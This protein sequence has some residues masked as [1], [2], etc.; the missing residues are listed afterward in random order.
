MARRSME[1]AV[2]ASPAWWCLVFAV[3]VD[4][5]PV[6]TQ[7][8]TAG[9]F[10]ALRTVDTFSWPN[11]SYQGRGIGKEARSAVLHLA[12]AGL[13]ARRA[14]SEAF[15]D[16]AAS[17]GVSRALGYRTDGTTWALRRGE[18]APMTRL[19]LTREEWELRRRS[20]MELRGLERTLEF[21]GLHDGS[22]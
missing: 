16:N 9:S 11:R 15:V 13:G 18:A 14:M 20:D 7:E 2:R 6:G 3:M 8:V 17:L 5:R 4:G 21:L 1:C 12:F 10:P 19:V 22:A